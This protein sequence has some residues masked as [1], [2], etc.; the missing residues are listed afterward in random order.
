MRVCARAV[1]VIVFTASGL[2]AHPTW[3][4]V[5]DVT[6]DGTAFCDG[7]ANDVSRIQAVIDTARPGDTILFPPDHVC[8]V[9]GTLSVT[10]QLRLAGGGSFQSYLTQLSASSVTI[11]V[12]TPAAVEIRDLVIEAPPNSTAACVQI[13]SPA[14]SNAQSHFERLMVTRCDV[15]I[16]FSRASLWA[17]TNSHF[18]A[19]RIAVEISNA[20]HADEGD[21]M[22]QGNVFLGRAQPAESYGVLWYSSGGLRVVNNKFNGF[23]TCMAYTP[24]DG[25]AQTG[26]TVITGNSMENWVNHAVLITPIGTAT[27][28]HFAITGN[29]IFTNSATPN[30]AA[31]SVNSASSQ[32]RAGGGTIT[33]NVITLSNVPAGFDYGILI[34]QADDIT[35]TGNTIIG[36]SAT[37][38]IG[39][40][41]TVGP[42]IVVAQNG[43][44]GVGFKFYSGSSR[45]LITESV[46]VQLPHVGIPADGSSVFCQDCRSVQEP[47]RPAVGSACVTGGTGALARRKNGAWYCY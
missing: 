44:S 35:V 13:A 16:R 38:G 30:A 14:D 11:S 17:V 26:L 25:T 23:T 36:S 24:P 41:P 4:R 21:S 2:V 37:L 7:S 45:A 8:A 12:N 10:K 43:Y 3:A 20:N 18:E 19:N 29:Q 46:P 28:R 34:Q 6:T 47:S 32:V 5:W 15:G 33:G 27:F 40:G 39:I 31:I 42:N 9:S 22:L 1:A